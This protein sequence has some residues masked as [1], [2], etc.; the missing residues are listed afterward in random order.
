[1]LQIIIVNRK[2]TMTDKDGGSEVEV[3]TEI[4]EED[5]NDILTIDTSEV[6]SSYGG[7]KD[8]SNSRPARGARAS[9]STVEAS[10]GVREFR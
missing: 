7:L 5:A 8:Y 10:K 9:K 4:K 3:K 6:V 1:M 2:T